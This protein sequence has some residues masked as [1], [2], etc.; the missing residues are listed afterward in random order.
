[1]VA[2]TAELMGIDHIGIGSDLCQGQPNSMVEWMR[3]GRWSKTTD[4]GE[5]SSTNAEWPAQPEWFSNST[6]YQ[7]VVQGLGDAGFPQQDVEKVMGQNWLCFFEHSF[8]PQN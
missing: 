5:G 8:G 7:N 1:M 2:D 6:H 4:Y 3:N